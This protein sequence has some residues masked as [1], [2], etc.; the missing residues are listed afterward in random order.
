MSD[1]DTPAFVGALLADGNIAGTAFVCASP[2]LIVTCA[3]S[4]PAEVRNLSWRRFDGSAMELNQ[5]KYLYFNE[6]L[7]IAVIGSAAPLTEPSLAADLPRH[8][9]RRGVE[10]YFNGVSR[11]IG[12]AGFEYPFDSGSGTVV[13][14]HMTANGQRRAK[15]Q[16][17]HVTQGCS[18]A[19]VMYFSDVGTTVVG[20]ISGRYNSPDWNRDTEPFPVTS[21]RAA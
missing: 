6:E 11:F 5:W 9:V 19:P 15:M 7:D 10:V 20:M 13:G 12:K 18:G 4:L 1:F 3:H 21:C 16:S 17:P 14:D 8:I 2:F